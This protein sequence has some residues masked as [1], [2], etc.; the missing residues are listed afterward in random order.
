MAAEQTNTSIRFENRFVLKIYRRLEEGMNSEIEIGRFLAKR[1]FPFV[2]PLAGELEYVTRAKR[3]RENIMMAV[4]HGWIPNQADAWKYTLD[5][6]SQFIEEMMARR[7]SIETLQSSRTH[8]LDMA[9]REMPA[10]S[11]DLIGSYLESARLLGERTAQLHIT[12]AAED[13]D[14]N[15]K[16]ERFTLLYQRSLYQSLINLSE[17]V[18]R[19]LEQRLKYLP[20]KIREEARTLLNM[21][22][23]VHSRFKSVMEAKFDAVRI[24]CHGNLHLRHILYTGNDFVIMDFGGDANR[25]LSERRIKRSPLRDVAGMVR[26]F[27]Y[28]SYS[29]LF[30]EQDAGLVRSDD[31]KYAESLIGFWN[32]W[33]QASFL[34]AYLEIAEGDDLL[35]DSREEL[36]TLLDVFILEK[37]IY[38]LGHE[39]NNRPNW[40]KIPLDG[41]RRILAF[42]PGE[43]SGGK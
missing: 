17:Q 30:F 14:K 27:E 25:S 10:S 18:F 7:P 32:L 1:G 13:D 41:I 2:P 12:L 4:L 42:K 20:D 35:P 3:R 34:K 24:R 11:Y 38:E 36:R 9:T 33:V 23:A 40:V 8:V 39:L 28:A 43:S 37:A 31:G 22:D 21:Q 15:F 6:L 29:A 16:P 5:V 19:L 26:S